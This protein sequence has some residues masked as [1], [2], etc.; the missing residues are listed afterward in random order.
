[1]KNLKHCLATILCLALIQTAYSV[2]STDLATK[3]M[4]N[5][6]LGALNDGTSSSILGRLKNNSESLL[7][8]LNKI[9]VG[10]SSDP[11][12]KNAALGN[13]SDLDKKID[14]YI[15]HYY[16]WYAA[17]TGF[18]TTIDTESVQK[19][20]DTEVKDKKITSTIGDIIKS[21]G[22]PQQYNICSIQDAVDTGLEKLLKSDIGYY[23]D[24]TAID[25]KKDLNALLVEKVEGGSNDIDKSFL[26]NDLSKNPFGILGFTPDKNM[27][28]GL[29]V[30]ALLGPDGYIEDKKTKKLEETN[31]KLFVNYVFQSAP[32]P[33][34][35]YIPPKKPA[36]K[37][38]VTVKFP[39]AIVASGDNDPKNEVQVSTEIPT[40]S[41]DFK[42]SYDRMLTYLG[43]NKTYQQYKLQ[44]RTLLALQS[45]FHGNILGSYQDRVK[46]ADANNKD[47]KLPSLVEKEKS[48]AMEGLVV[49]YE[50]LK[51][52]SAADINLETLH[53]LNK[54]V[55]FL[56]K[57]HQ[58][59][60]RLLLVNTISSMQTIKTLSMGFEGTY[61]TPISK[62]IANQC[63]DKNKKIND[64]SDDQQKARKKVCDD[65]D[66]KQGEN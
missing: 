45:L 5:E 53:A 40:D 15:D 8:A 28:G 43:E 19:A 35:F 11:N 25:R 34:G 10:E 44:Y 1:M 23:I 32:L 46:T 64:E 47:K 58:D 24:E 33:E 48:M 62:M 63:W 14:L 55:Y 36:K 65:I 22:T 2:T 41:D 18:T 4:Q 66:G 59:N 29:S 60:E 37:N 61:I 30:D 49:P 50:E 57:L 3:S 54:L 13:Q 9:F 31:A 6:I 27:P 26:G 52:K 7:K 38:K 51:K 56:H 17:D 42:T 12:S 20:I 16:D 21:F 39:K